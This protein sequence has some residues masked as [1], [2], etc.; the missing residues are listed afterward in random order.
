MS[1]PFGP[2]PKEQLLRAIVLIVFL[3]II[4]FGL[5]IAATVV[6]SEDQPVVHEEMTV[7][8]FGMGQGYT[9]AEPIVRVRDEAGREYQVPGPSNIGDSCQVGDT[10]AIQRQGIKLQVGVARCQSTPSRSD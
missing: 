10:I 8:G 2:S 7:I 6:I 9:G 1:D 3:A 5:W 4:G